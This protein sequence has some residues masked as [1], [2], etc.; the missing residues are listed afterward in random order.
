MAFLHTNPQRRWMK[1]LLAVAV[2]LSVPH[3]IHAQVYNG[4]GIQGGLGLFAGL[5]GIS[6]AT[7]LEE[8]IMIIITYVLDIILFVAVL[9]VIVAGVYL[10]VSNGSDENKDKA[11]KIIFYVI[12]GIIL[13]LFARIIVMVVNSIFF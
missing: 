12:A 4:N 9:A 1:I 7:S 13:I 5:G 2:L 11:K 8:L 10:I 3:V 6:S